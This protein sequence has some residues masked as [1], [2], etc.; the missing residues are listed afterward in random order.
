[1]RTRGSH[2]YHIY[3]P[4]R[5]RSQREHEHFNN[6]WQLQSILS[7]RLIGEHYDWIDVLWVDYCRLPSGLFVLVYTIFNR[8]SN[9]RLL[10]QNVTNLK[11]I[12]ISISF[13]EKN[14][15]IIKF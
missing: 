10:F 1:M 5:Q 14:L 9:Y 15:P 12:E 3:S 7:E 11:D 6:V 4:G 2:L 8:N 13:L